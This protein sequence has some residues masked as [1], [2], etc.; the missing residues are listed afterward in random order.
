MNFELRQYSSL[1]EGELFIAQNNITYRRVGGTKSEEVYNP[2]H[3]FVSFHSYD[4]VLCVKKEGSVPEDLED[5]LLF[6][7]FFHTYK[8]SRPYIE[9]RNLMYHHIKSL[10]DDLLPFISDEKDN[11]FE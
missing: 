4:P 8:S 10:F 5:R 11:Y 7:L 6:K 1:E 3:T 9:E 2:H